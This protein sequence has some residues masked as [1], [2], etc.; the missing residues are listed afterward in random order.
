MAI[1]VETLTRVFAY[2]GMELPDP[3]AQFTAIQVRDIYAAS[4]PELATAEV[5]GPERKGEKL[6][7]S[8]A[9]A[10]GTKGLSAPRLRLTVREDGLAYVEAA[11][12]KGIVE[13]RLEAILEWIDEAFLKMMGLAPVELAARNEESL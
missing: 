11:P 1:K 4:Y 12:P 5:N 9:R 8:F 6:V 13:D 2:A 7:F 3:G 10:V